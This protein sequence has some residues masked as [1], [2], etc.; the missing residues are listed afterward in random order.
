LIGAG[1]HVDRELCQF[2][3]TEVLPGTGVAADGFWQAY[4][5]LLAEL[6][7][8][9]AELLAERD[10]LQARIDAYF[11]DRRGREHDAAEYE[12]F[13]REIGYLVDDQAPLRIETENVDPEIGLL[14]GPQ[15]VV[16]VMNARFALNAANARWGSLYDALYGT[17]A[18]PQTGELAAGGTYNEKRGAAVVTAA[19]AFLDQA[20]PLVGAQHADVTRYAIA[21]GGLEIVTPAGAVHL[22]DP[23]AFR[24]YAHRGAVTVLL[25]GHNGL[26]FEIV[27]DSSTEVGRRDPAGIADIVIESALTTIQDCEDSV[28]AVDAQ[29]K[30][31]VYRNW[32]GLMKGDL[33]ES[34]IKSG[35]EIT[36]RLSPDRTYIGADGQGLILPGRSLM[37]GA[38][39][40]PFDADRCGARC[41]QEPDAG[42]VPRR[43][44]DGRRGPA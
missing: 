10:R 23:G 34:F 35:H 15:L 8:R 25:F 2:V 36:R 19:K 22:L 12:A 21:D 6:A 38:Q 18:V 11:R 29:D 5:G 40:R 33:K 41:R 27:I 28:A 14:A 3:E 42:G 26:H 9:N 31:V 30:V 4:A 20:L 16:P 17:D 13:L 37:L 39:C 1:L 24:G 43:H 44:G 32:L 7:P